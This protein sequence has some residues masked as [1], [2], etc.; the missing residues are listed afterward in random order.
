MENNNN[1]INDDIINDINDDISIDYNVQPLCTPQLIH[2]LLS[3]QELTSD[4]LFF[5][6]WAN[7]YFY[8]LWDNKTRSFL[9]QAV[10][11]AKR[12]LKCV[13]PWLTDK[14]PMK[15][16]WY[17]DRLETERE[18][19]ILQHNYNHWFKKCIES[20][21][22]YCEKSDSKGLL[23]KCKAGVCLQLSR[24][25]DYSN[26]G[27]LIPL[28]IG[29]Y[30]DLKKMNFDSFYEIRNPG[31]DFDGKFRGWKNFALIGPQSLMNHDENS[32]ARLLHI[33]DNSRSFL[34]KTNYQPPISR[35]VFRATFI[36]DLA[37]RLFQPNE[38]LFI[39]KTN[40]RNPTISTVIVI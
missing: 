8:G 31:N 24:V 40:S 15:S 14:E 9:K 1:D 19:L 17:P 38:E 7:F 20:P 22:Y 11:A 13:L 3:K 25:F 37:C 2:Y 36:Q 39:Y 21:W 16:R 4:L 34:I 6:S 10:A 28:S 27:I 33:K 18:R 26:P 30:N 12:G 29:I 32:T 35:C 23:L 5:F